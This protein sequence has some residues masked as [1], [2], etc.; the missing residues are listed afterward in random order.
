MV[1]NV[2]IVGVGWMGRGVAQVCAQR[3][4]DVVINDL[5][6]G[7]LEQ[8]RQA[9]RSGLDFMI[10]QGLVSKGDADLA[11]SRV[12]STLDFDDA[13][14]AADL[15]IEAIPEVLDMKKELF[16]RLDRVC[17]P[18]A[19]LATNTSTLS[20][21]A[22]A[23]AT[24]QPERVVGIHWF[25]PAFV[26]P[27][28]EII[29]G[30]HTSD[31][32]VNTARDFVLKLGKIPIVLRKEAPGFVINR[33]QLALLNEATCLLE[34]GIATAE[35]IDNGARM[36]LGIKLPFWGPLK[37][38]DL[39]VTKKTML[40]AYEYLYKET[41]SDKYRPPELLKE[42]VSKGELGLA[43]GKGY[44]DYTKESQDAVARE[45]DTMVIKQLKFLAELGYVK[46][47]W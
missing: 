42:M 16:T 22:I 40:N 21:S 5:E 36:V 31:Q 39:A 10:E 6:E 24:S 12:K 11:M 26:M 28:V 8:A 7:I 34:Q 30:A 32:T 20:I 35:D 27:P 2:T 45:R 13:V 3:G 19:I 1:K 38:E 14:K 4:Y 18:Q 43:S 44:Y 25:Y 15:V 9:V 37:I 47:P 33:L 23:A 46:F 17:R 41:G 29:R